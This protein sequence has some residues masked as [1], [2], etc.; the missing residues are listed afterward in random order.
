MSVSRNRSRWVGLLGWRVGLLLAISLVAFAAGLFTLT[1]DARDQWN[2]LASASRDNNGWNVA[3]SEVEFLRVV[4]AVTIAAAKG[5]PDPELLSDVRLRFDVFYSRMTTLRDSSTLAPARNTE[6][7]RNL[8]A[9]VFAG[10]NSLIPAIDG[11]DEVL[12]QELPTISETLEHYRS[13]VR[14]LSLNGSKN[15]TV[16]AFERRDRVIVALQKLGILTV[17]LVLGLMVLVVALVVLIVRER[18][19]QRD[20]Q[21]ISNRLTSIIETALEG[22][23]VVDDQSK[24]VEFNPAAEQIFGYT[25]DQVL[26]KKA[27]EL[28]LDEDQRTLFVSALG[29]LTPSSSGSSL[30]SG[31]FQIQ[32]LRNGGEKFPI[33]ISLSETESHDET[34][35]VTFV[36]DISERLQARRQI[37]EARDKA[38]AGEKAKSQMLLIMSHEMRTPLNGI[39]GALELMQNT[40][41]N[42]IQR[43][44]S[45]AIEASGQLLLRHV[46][47]AMDISVAERNQLT[48]E[49]NEFDL[50]SAI[51][52]V[53][54]S[55]KAD[56]EGRGNTLVVSLQ[57]GLQNVVG[58]IGRVQQILGNLL[59][60]AIQHTENG[61]VEIGINR[62]D[63]GDTVEFRVTDTG[64]GIAQ[65]D[66]DRI[67]DDFVRLDS[68]FSRGNEG[69]GL[70]LGIVRRLVEVM[71]GE[72]G[73][74]SKLSD[75]SVFWV[76][77]P[78]P[79]VVEETPVE[80]EAPAQ[81]A[82]EQ[83]GQNVLV[84]EDNMINRLV[85][86]DMLVKFGC[87]VTEAVNGEVGVNEAQS[88]KF[89]LILM[90]ISM[91]VMDGVTATQ[92]IKKSGKNMET[93]VFAVTAHAQPDE[94]KAFEEAG[95][96]ETIIK[97]LTIAK[98]KTTLAAIS[99]SA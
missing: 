18:Q 75:G 59:A 60:N 17:A 76:T 33:E 80:P 6:L 35:Q 77:L 57:D 5:D 70:G 31:R 50:R 43:K 78:L 79:A 93:P 81:P 91:P 99:A 86:K 82:F 40:D 64:I 53:V 7:S 90:D 54:D 52:E 94:I 85:I 68:S 92:L 65:A 83:Y 24:I 1:K 56:A 66:I 63:A 9:G 39:L 28:L 15:M 20:K 29:R 21:V 19:H 97:P 87:Q 13:D 89:D 46:N 74:E 34:L 48:V 27:T 36:R 55:M 10:L 95:I 37:E 41:L 14:T 98:L 44:Y 2:E 30:R 23:V 49:Q 62:L 45:Q 96:D 61:K 26:G 12:W 67:F 42:P 25:R 11:S 4:N 16:E 8:I 73:V 84:V 71:N 72:I 3:Q 22:V 32:A 58:D 69:T 51:D 38:M 47:T 88:Q